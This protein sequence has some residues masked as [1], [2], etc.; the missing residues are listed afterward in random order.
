MPIRTTP[1]VISALLPK[2]LPNQLPK[3]TPKRQ[4]KNVIM[5]IS[6]DAKITDT[7]IVAKVMPTAS[8]SMLVAIARMKSV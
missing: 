1:P 4:I 3:Y 7:A 6:A 8:A 2:R 5:P